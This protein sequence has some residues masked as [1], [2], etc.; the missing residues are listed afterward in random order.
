[1]LAKCDSA[2]WQLG[3]VGWVLSLH[4]QG[5]AFVFGVSMALKRAVVG[6]VLQ[7]ALHCTELCRAEGQQ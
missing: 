5:Q 3:C 4:A 6:A 1:M 2:S 7:A